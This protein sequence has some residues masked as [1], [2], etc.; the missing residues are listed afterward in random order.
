ML[1]GGERFGVCEYDPPYAIHYRKK[2]ICEQ[3]NVHFYLHSDEPIIV[4][5]M[6][7]IKGDGFDESN[8]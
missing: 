3:A 2:C 6:V 4:G 1:H 8:A 5:R 7:H